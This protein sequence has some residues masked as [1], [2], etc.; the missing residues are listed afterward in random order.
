MDR[1]ASLGAF[2]GPRLCHLPLVTPSQYTALL[3]KWQNVLLSLP[4]AATPPLGTDRSFYF[5]N[6]Y[7]QHRPCRPTFFF[8]TNKTETCYHQPFLKATYML[9][10]DK[11]HAF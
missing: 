11:G 9:R 2:A 6:E 8:L 7:L 5:K 3:A 1:S 10:G 4:A